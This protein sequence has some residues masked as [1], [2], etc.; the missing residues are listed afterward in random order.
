MG[1]L[2]V[3]YKPFK[4]WMRQATRE[5]LISI[6]PRLRQADKD[7]TIATTGLPPEAVLPM[8][9][10]EGTCVAGPREMNTPEM[11]LGTY[12]IIGS[13]NAGSVWMLST[14]VLFDYAPRFAAASPVTV[15]AMHDGY[16]LLTNFIDERNTRHIIW[17]KWLG[18][19]MIRRIDKFGPHSLPFLE[20][21]SYKP[22]AYH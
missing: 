19:R 13:D 6:A 2:D 4:A 15:E 21:A 1:L 11:V 18:F 20:F 16:D 17:L 5:D 12:P 10:L 7:E 9:P 22:C 3:D 8:A 14:D